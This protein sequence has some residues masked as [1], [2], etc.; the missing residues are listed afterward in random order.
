M[1]CR[2]RIDN[3]QAFCNI[4]VLLFPEDKY[5]VRNYLTNFTKVTRDVSRDV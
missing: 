5:S 4:F 2:Y 1:M 3:E